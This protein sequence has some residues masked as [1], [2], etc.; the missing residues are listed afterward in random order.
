MLSGGITLLTTAGTVFTAYQA[1]QQD[2]QIGRLLFYVLR[3]GLLFR[4]FCK[5][6]LENFQRERSL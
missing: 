1:Y 5:L 3:V 6:V 4:F 2:A